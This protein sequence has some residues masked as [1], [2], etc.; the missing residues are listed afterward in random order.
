MPFKAEYEKWLQNTQKEQEIQHELVNMTEAEKEDAFRCDLEFGTAGLRGI[1]GAGTN[2]MNKY[3][4]GK[5]SQGVANYLRKHYQE[6]SVVIGF[7]SRIN[8]EAFAKKAAGVFAAN[9]I[10]VQL[11]PVLMPVP[12]VSFATRYLHA[13]AGIMITA[14]HNPGQYNGYKV[15]GA[16][17]CQI[18]TQAAGAIL[19]EINDIDVF[20]G[21]KEVAFAEGIKAGTI[22]YIADAVYDAFITKVQEQSVLFGDEVD[23]NVS[24]VYS[25]LNGTG[26]RPVTRILQAM[27]YTNITVVKEQEQPDGNFYYLPLSQSG[28]KRSYDLGHCLCP[29]LQC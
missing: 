23:K 22:V 26:L 7:D 18:T 1:M 14:S 9:G 28:D 4:V 20:T 29:K 24:I 5:A 25:P 6:P 12:L 17:G 15:Y 13:S 10:K 2:R 11:W 3:I 16:D 27:G 19:A 21:V 8:S